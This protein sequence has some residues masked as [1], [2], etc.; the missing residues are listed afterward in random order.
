MSSID[1]SHGFIDHA[2]GLIEH[3]RRPWMKLSQVLSSIE[4]CAKSLKEGQNHG[5]NP[6]LK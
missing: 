4:L 1:E 6:S 5:F 2:I 3:I